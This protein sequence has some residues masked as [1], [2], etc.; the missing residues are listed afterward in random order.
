MRNPIKIY[1]DWIRRKELNDKIQE[2]N[3]EIQIREFNGCVCL[4]Y[5]N[6]PLVRASEFNDEI[7][8]VVKR[9]REL[10]TSTIIP[11]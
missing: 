3:D 2:L 7:C 1:M 9:S 10:A 11:F 5:K 6:I 4:C 8:K